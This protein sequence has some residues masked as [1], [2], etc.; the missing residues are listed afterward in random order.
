[1]LKRKSIFNSGS[2]FKI[3]KKRKT[4]GDSN[5]ETSEKRKRLDSTESEDNPRFG[6]YEAK[7]KL[8]SATSYKMMLP[9]LVLI[10]KEI[11]RKKDFGKIKDRIL[12]GY[13]Y[14]VAH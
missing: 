8:L 5:S 3:P 13:I 14:C 11:E 12:Q 4:S 10:K 2:G 7:K 9:Q 6:R 1:M